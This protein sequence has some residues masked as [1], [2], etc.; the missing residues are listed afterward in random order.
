M[1]IK[2]ILNCLDKFASLNLQE[3]YDN[4]GLIIGNTDNEFKKALICLDCTEEII[5]EAINKKCNLIISHHPLIFDGLKKINSNT[6]TGRSVIK[7]IKNDISLFAIH[8]NI[9]NHVKGLNSILAKKLGLKNCRVLSPMKDILRKIVTFCPVEHAEKVRN[10]LFD[11]G[12]GHIGNYDNCSYNITG[13]GSFRALEN[14][15]PFVGEISKLHFEKEIRIETVFPVYKQKEIIE[16]LKKS[17]PYEEIAFDIYA[18]DNE[19]KFA[20]AGI[21]G[22]LEQEIETREYLMKIKEI[23]K[24]KCLK[25]SK[26][27]KQKIKKVAVCGGA[28][29]FLIKNAHE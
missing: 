23:T 18:L 15:N 3:S 12:A 8:T 1:Q 5:E 29:G 24:V 26:I 27:D 7:A 25:F 4:S 6:H 28:G 10:A 9:D 11:A 17:H 16:A 2:E 19:C 20:G 21:I 22:E 13:E 14:A